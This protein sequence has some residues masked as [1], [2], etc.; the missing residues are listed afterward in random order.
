M[1]KPI[2]M[3]KVK[4]TRR[5]WQSHEDDFV[6]NNQNLSNEELAY[7]LDRTPWGLY[8]RR[9]ILG[10]ERGEIAWDKMHDKIKS[11]EQ[12]MERVGYLN[13]DPVYSVDTNHPSHGSIVKW[14]KNLVS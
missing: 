9:R 7:Y 14:F 10:L 2:Q 4:I 13:G 3:S 12:L 6:R 8:E 1:S 11:K 5:R